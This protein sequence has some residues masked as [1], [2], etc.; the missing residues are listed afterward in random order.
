MCSLS[1]DQSYVGNYSLQLVLVGTVDNAATFGTFELAGR[2]ALSYIAIVN[3]LD[4]GIPKEVLGVSKQGVTTVDVSSSSVAV[5]IQ[6]VVQ[7]N[8]SEVHGVYV[9]LGTGDNEDEDD[10]LRTIVT[11]PTSVAGKHPWAS[12]SAQLF[13]VLLCLLQILMATLL[14]RV[15]LSWPTDNIP[16]ILT[17]YTPLSMVRLWSYLSLRPIHP[18]ESMSCS[19]LTQSIFEPS[20]GLRLI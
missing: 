11:L 14:T 12:P 19:A 1:F 5:D 8:Q 13:P 16:V 20:L 17:S 15:L 3:L 9:A 7:D 4:D 6:L 10:V 18:Y 2:S